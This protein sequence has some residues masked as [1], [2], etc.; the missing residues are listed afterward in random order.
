[1]RTYEEQQ[2]NGKLLGISLLCTYTVQLITYEHYDFAF[3]SP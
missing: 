1:M 3:G 2:Y